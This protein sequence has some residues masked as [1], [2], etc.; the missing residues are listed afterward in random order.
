MNATVFDKWE[1]VEKECVADCIECGSCSYTCPANRPLLDY[2]HLGKN[3][4][5]GMVR[6]R[7]SS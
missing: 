6:A 1:L 3:K 5:A 4:V 7:K 2:I